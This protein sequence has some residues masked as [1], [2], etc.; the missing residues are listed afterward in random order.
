MTKAKSLGEES[1]CKY[2][3]R[4]GGQEVSIWSKLGRKKAWNKTKL[5]KEARDGLCWDF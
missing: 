3:E 1:G 4:K 2:K 5:E